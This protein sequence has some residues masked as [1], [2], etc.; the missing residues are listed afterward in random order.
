MVQLIA[1]SAMVAR[2]ADIELGR[3]L[4][5]ECV[6]CHSVATGGTIPNIFGMAETTF[7]EVMRAYREK[8]LPNEVMRSIASRLSDEDI[9]SLALFF[10][11]TK[12]P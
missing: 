11:T 2:P 5:T 7:A 8:Q 10:A 4:A 3:Y 6:T 9:A 12:K 1:T